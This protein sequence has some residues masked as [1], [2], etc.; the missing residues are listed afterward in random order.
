VEKKNGTA[1]QD[2]ADNITKHTWFA[3]WINKA[4]DIKSEYVIHIA[5]RRHKRLRE[6]P[7]L[8]GLYIHC[9]SYC[10]NFPILYTAVQYAEQNTGD[11]SDQ[12]T[13]QFLSGQ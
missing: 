3:C 13:L 2:T 6:R 10:T 12:K 8:L 7:S 4:K 5:F 11:C 9:L 1:T